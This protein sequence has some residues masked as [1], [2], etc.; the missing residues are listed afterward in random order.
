LKNSL[1]PTLAAEEII[2]ATGGNL[3]QGSGCH[4]F[5]G[6]S[7]DSRNITGD[8]LFI[9]VVG[10]RYDGH[11]FIEEALR[12]G[13]SGLLLQR[14]KEKAVEKVSRDVPVI[15]VDDTLKALGDI[16]RFWRDRFKIPVVAVTGSSG[17]TTTKEMIAS[18]AGL[19]MNILKSPGNFNNLIGLPLTLLSDSS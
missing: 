13:A 3:I 14:G 1:L 4:V 16:A 11:D 7:T 6:V 2:K 10:D 8:T 17:K 15:C 12:S 18:I 19:S 5:N 9:P